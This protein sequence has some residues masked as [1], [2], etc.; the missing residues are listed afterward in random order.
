MRKS[1]NRAMF[2]TAQLMI[3]QNAALSNPQAP[4]PV[5]KVLTAEEHAARRR[6]QIT[7]GYIALHERYKREAQENERRRYL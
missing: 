2:E 7:D 5:E 1:V 4:A 6:Q 3:Q